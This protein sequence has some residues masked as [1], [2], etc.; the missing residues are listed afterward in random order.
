MEVRTN[1]SQTCDVFRTD[2]QDL[3]ALVRELGNAGQVEGEKRDIEWTLSVEGQGVTLLASSTADLRLLANDDRIPETATDFDLTI[4]W[5]EP[6][7]CSKRDLTISARGFFAFRPSVTADCPDDNE[8]WCLQICAKTE[9]KLARRRSGAF[10][11]YRKGYVWAWWAIVIGLLGVGVWIGP[12]T[13]WTT[14]R[15]EW[16]VIAIA[17]AMALAGI[18][19]G[20]IVPTSSLNLKEDSKKKLWVSRFELTGRLLPGFLALTAALLSHC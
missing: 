14:T 17:V 6:V 7:S 9:R 18:Q 15:S 19:R 11:V 1:K 8:A 5:S 10:W 3:E 12:I 13:E 2:L 4:Y 16:T 20:R